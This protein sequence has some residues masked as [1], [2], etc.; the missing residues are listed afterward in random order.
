MAKRREKVETVTN[1]LFLGFKITAD[2]DC[3]YEIRRYSILGM[4]IM[5]NLDSTLKSRRHFANKGPN[6]QS[7]GLSSSHARMWELDHKEGWA[8]KNWCFRTVVLEKTLES[9]LDSK[10][11]KS[12]NPKGNQPWILTGR[13]DAEVPILWPPDGNSQLIGRDSDAG[14]DW[15]QKENMAADKEKFG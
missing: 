15:R 14:K 9:P 1:F 7:H 13:T 2:N 5:T 3:S 12:V 6:S 4:K 10:E 8:L 11:I